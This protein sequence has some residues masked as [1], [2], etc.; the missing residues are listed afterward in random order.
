MDQYIDK[1]RAQT[2][3]YKTRR[4]RAA[5]DAGVPELFSFIDHFPLYC[6]TQTLARVLAV[7]EIFK[8]CQQV[9]GHIVEFG[10]FKGGN[11]MLMA[12]LLQMFQ[13]AT[14]KSVFGF[15]S[16]EGL[17]DF[18]REDAAANR[19]DRVGTYKGNYEELKR[20]IKVYD[21]ES[22]VYLVK[23]NALNT[24]PAF[25]KEHPDILFSLAYIDF[26][27][28][29]PCKEALR[30]VHQRLCP[31]GII[32]FDEALLHNWPG[33]GQVM[34]EFLREHPGEY[35]S[36]CMPFAKQPTAFLIRK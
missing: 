9:P 29:G 4:A 5:K 12:K 36:A 13:P 16:F 15:D 7:Y 23:G 11:L 10:C 8:R 19:P 31:G 21:L 2:Q 27:L 32:A 20:W 25:E 1:G 22:V 3:A 6:G 30:F 17:Q 33:E 18:S 35:E 14:C 26:D 24:I 34:A 28:Y